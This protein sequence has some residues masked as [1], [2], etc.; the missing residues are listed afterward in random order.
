MKMRSFVFGVAL[1][2]SLYANSQTLFTYG[3]H[4]VDV[5]EFLRAFNKV[6]Q[7]TSANREKAIRSYLDLY[8]NS[9][10]KIQH[11]YEMRLDTLPILNDEL[12]ALRSQVIESYMS[13]PETIRHLLEEAFIRSQKDISVSH[14]FVPYS[15]VDTASAFAA[16]MSAHNE[17]RAGKKFEEVAK[18]WSKDP[19]VHINGGDLGFLTVFSL[20]YQFENIV[21]NLAPGT[22]N[23]PFKSGFGYH[24]F[25]NASERKAIGKMKAAQLLLAFPPGADE[26]TKKQ[27][28]RLADSLYTLIRKG[29]D[30]T[31]LTLQYSND[32][33]SNAAGGQMKEISVGTYDPVFEKA[34]FGLVKN[35]DVSKPFATQHGYH[36]VQ[37][38]ALIPISTTRDQKTLDELKAK[39]DNDS[40]VNLSKQ[41]LY[42]RIIAKAPVVLHKFDEKQLYLFADSLI[43]FKRP[44]EP[45]TSITHK[46]EL[47]K[48]GDITK[49]AFDYV[50]YAINNR[51]LSDGSAIKPHSR[52]MEEFKLQT[53][54]DYY[55]DHLEDFNVDFRNQMNDFKEG[56]LFFEVMMEKVWGPAQN[57]T[58]A[59]R[60]YYNTHR[61]KYAWKH[62]ADA[63]IFY[64]GDDAL[65]KLVHTA[66]KSNPK[67]WREQADHYGDRMTVDSGRFETNRIPGLTAVTA[68]V[69]FLTPIVKNTQDKSSA[70]AYILKI[71]TQPAQK[72]F[73]QAKG[74]VITDYQEELEAQWIAELK[75]KYPVKINEEVLRSTFR[76]Q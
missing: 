36:I 50:N 47:F 42:E 43:D 37:R 67:K 56:N 22:F 61:S 20:P 13:D 63:V 32:Y 4:S 19:N 5:K 59:Q 74:E 11:A 15:G 27:I 55:R 64:T 39:L 75:R 65:A 34:L 48:F 53:A 35:G 29:E 40:R 24:I 68:R 3:P 71:Y 69:G 30:F 76:N 46:T 18:K 44:A 45:V 72:T 2:L 51:Y 54:M 12:K 28:G 49:T 66:I 8:I 10:L 6:D 33:V 60:K 25:L 70:F 38:I 17:L 26:N 14:I 23:A 1:L 57:D 16:I 58:V 31:K 41:R 62:S 9:K 7:G 73:S 21:Y 52:I